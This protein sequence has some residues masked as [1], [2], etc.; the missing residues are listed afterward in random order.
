MSRF[1]RALEDLR[2]L[3]GV[4]AVWERRVG[5]EF[6]VVRGAFLQVLPEP[7][8]S[9]P[10]PAECGCAHAVVR[11]DDGRIVAVCQCDPWNCDNFA[12]TEADLVEYALNGAKLGRAL[13]RAFGCE[14]K[15][16]EVGVPGTRQ[17]GALGGAALPIVLTIVHERWQFRSVVAELA[18]RLRGGFVLLAPT[19]RFLDATAQE[20]LGHARAGFCDLESTVTLLPG[21]TLQ[22][23][24]SGGELFSA[25]LPERPEEYSEEDVRRLYARV[26][27]ACDTDATT[28]EAPLKRVFD[29]YC[30][31]GLSAQDVALKLNCAKATVI[32]RL[33]RLR[34]MT[35][36]SAEA[37]RGYRPVFAR[38]EASITDPRARQVRRKDAIYGDDAGEEGD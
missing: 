2:G 14:A 29:L 19:N 22:A 35:G 33:A 37:L 1:W 25:Y 10:C 12:V 16:G 23:R 27:L 30:M 21:G 6:A 4:A 3:A 31:A 38:I 26:L 13:A 9:V 32:N 5:A 11:H 34:E 36:V 7:A 18:A 20:L 15:I 8:A 24:K 17:V 28:R